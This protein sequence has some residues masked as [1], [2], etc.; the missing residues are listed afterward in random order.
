[1]QMLSSRNKPSKPG[2]FWAGYRERAR[3]LLTTFS[4]QLDDFK[5]LQ[6]TI[7]SFAPPSLCINGRPIPQ[8]FIE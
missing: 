2:D 4:F 6:N 5:G 7:K 8:R 1:M 3:L